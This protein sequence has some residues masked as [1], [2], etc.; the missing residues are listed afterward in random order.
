MKKFA[1]ILLLILSQIDSA[2]TQTTTEIEEQVNSQQW[3]DLDSIKVKKYY[4]LA[5]T[6]SE[7]NFQKSLDYS[8]K[9]FELAKQIGFKRFLYVFKVTDGTTYQNA[10]DLAASVLSLKDGLKYATDINYINGILT[11]RSTLLNTY[12]LKGDYKSA[13]DMAYENERLIKQYGDL[14]T[15]GTTYNIFAACFIEMKF[16]KK[17]IHYLQL[18]ANESA[19]YSEPEHQVTAYINIAQIYIEEKDYSNALLHI[20]KAKKIVT[21][22]FTQNTLNRIKSCEADLLKSQ[23]KFEEADSIRQTLI[24]QGKAG[25]DPRFFSEQNR[26]MAVIFLNK[27]KIDSALHYALIAKDFSIKAQ[28]LS[29][30]TKNAETLFNIYKSM[31]NLSMALTE[32][33]N[34]KFLSDSAINLSKQ[35]D[36]LDLQEKYESKLKEEENKKLVLEKKQ[37]TKQLYF[38]ILLGIAVISVIALIAYLIFKNKQKVEKLNL[39]ITEQKDELE[40]RN[41]FKDELFS[42]ISHDLRSPLTNLQTLLFIQDKGLTP[43][44]LEE[45][46]I[47]IQQ[48]LATTSEMLEN[49]LVWSTKNLDADIKITEEDLAP[50]VYQAFK[51]VKIQ[52]ELKNVSLKINTPLDEAIVKV[53][54]SKFLFCLRNILT[55]AIKFSNPDSDIHLTYSNGVL[56]IRDYGK[57]MQIDQLKALQEGKN[58]SSELGTNSEKGSGIGMRLVHQFCRA[59]H[60]QLKIE[61]KINE[62]TVVYFQW[63]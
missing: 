54:S 42:I 30:Q 40:K 17:A 33:E 37:K 27:N 61:S 22:D 23:Q 29:E 26:K 1:L 2:Q 59:Q 45:H 21:K 47:Q 51:D 36:I 57:G 39:Q 38:A 11:A 5:W 12:Y 25:E 44:I 3:L 19:R 9:G 41:L 18:Y 46:Q 14:K 32:L 24:K 20:N 58:K 10:G 4:K 48:S 34:L 56:S 15:L 28:S 31:G 43:K 63:E 52:A 62:G 35:K 55:N 13:T 49:L 6:Y 16:Y 53:H 7:T 8:K 60:I 50:I